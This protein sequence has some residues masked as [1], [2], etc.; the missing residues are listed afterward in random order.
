MSDDDSNLL[1]PVGGTEFSWC[2]AVPVGTGITVLALSL[3]KPP[4]ISYLQNTLH[5]FQTS[6]PILNS[7]IH[8]NPTTKSFSYI[9]RPNPDLQIQPFD[10][11][12]TAQILHELQKDPQ[13]DAVTPFQLILEHELNRNSWRDPNDDANVFFASLYYLSEAQWVL[14]LRLHTSV[15][16]RAAAAAL[17]RG[18]LREMSGGGERERGFEGNGEVSLGIEEIIPKGKANKPFWVRGV[19]MVGYS[20]NSFRLSNLEFVEP[21]SPRQSRVVRLQMNSFH[22]ENLLTGCTSRGIKVCA[23]LAAAGLIAAHSSKKLPQDHKEKYA[24]VTL[25]DCRS[26]LEPPLSNNNLG[27]YHSAI[28]NTHDVTGRDTLWELATKSYKSYANAKNSNKHFTD[29]S[30]LNFLMCKAIENPSLTPSSAMRTAFMSVFE[31]PIIDQTDELQQ[32]ICLEDYIGCASA[33]GVGPSIAVFDTIRGGSLDCTMVYPSP[34]HS[35]EQIQD[36]IDRMK[37][38]LVDACVSVD[39]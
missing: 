3:S 24:V 25:T 20:L 6:Q 30:D 29:M 26:I 10:L 4:D 23:A 12:S 22:T 5:R 17:L 16:D 31:D 2:K 18:L 21:N 32:E 9:R 1:R 13:N 14:A 35:R 38:I 8:F 36:L 33:H 11:Q 15:C 39:V 37:N 19:D 34:L 27:F 28:L 7:Y